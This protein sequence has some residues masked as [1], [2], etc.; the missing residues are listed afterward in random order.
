M[1]TSN[2]IPRETMLRQ[3]VG[4][5]KTWQDYT[6]YIGLVLLII[7]SVAINPT[8]STSTNIMNIFKQVATPGLLAIGMT[9][10]IITGGI[11]LSVGSVL[12]VC[13][14]TMALLTPSIG[15]VAASTIALLLGIVV[16]LFFGVCIT[17]LNVPAFIATLAG[18]TLLRGVALVVTKSAAVPVRSENFSKLGTSNASPILCYAILGVLAMLVIKTFLTDRN[19]GKNLPLSA[20]KAVILLV[21]IAA[22]GMFINKTK[23]INIQVI[24]F[25]GIF[26]IFLVL[27]NNTTFGR[28][29]YALGGNMEA[30]RLAG[31]KVHRNL[32]MVY[33]ISGFTAAMGGVLAAAR[34]SSAAPQAG[35]TYETDAICAVVIGGTSLAGGSGKLTGTLIGV[36]LIGVLNNLLSLENVSSDM[37]M[38]FKGVIVLIAVVL[39]TKLKRNK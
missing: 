32:I 21:I 20:L 38:I 28:Q 22:C 36:L 13:G 4:D 12:A 37:Q 23:G 26:L 27:L 14:V 17:K 1:K 34:L 31:V 8:F 11:D 39:D 35:L 16:G 5:K 10:A 7:L 3:G 2:A 18:Q 9:F 6:S 24:I 33:A 29:V 25:G 19:T 15:W 30:A